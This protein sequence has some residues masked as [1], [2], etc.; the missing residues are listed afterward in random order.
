MFPTWQVLKGGVGSGHGAGLGHH[1]VAAGHLR[2]VGGGLGRTGAT[3]TPVSHL[4]TTWRE[5]YENICSLGKF[6]GLFYFLQR[7]DL[8]VSFSFLSMLIFFLSHKNNGSSIKYHFWSRSL[9]LIWIIIHFRDLTQFKF[10][11]DQGKMMN[12]STYLPPLS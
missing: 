3:P 8:S 2:V 9:K 12:G 1:H 7:K 6:Q 10:Y 5:K 11:L 4:V